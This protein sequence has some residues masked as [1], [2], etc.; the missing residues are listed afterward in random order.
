MILNNRLESEDVKLS[1][2][3]Y[4][5]V[6][7][8]TEHLMRWN[9][10]HNLTGARTIKDIENNIY[11]AVY[12]IKFLPK[13]KSVIDIGTGAGFPGMLLAIALPNTHFT[14]VEPLQKRS[15]F[16]QFIVATLKLKNVK[17]ETKRVEDL[18][19]TKVDLITSRAVT[20]TKLLMELSKEFIRKDTLILFYKGSSV[21]EEID[22]SLDYRIIQRDNRRYLLI[23]SK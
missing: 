22:E 11:D 2:E 1:P 7:I 12:P 8:F 6:N 23:K 10:I 19:A 15:S 4:K 9:K 17:V 20:D 5:N 21:E 3:F 18:E 13:V 16:L 14:L